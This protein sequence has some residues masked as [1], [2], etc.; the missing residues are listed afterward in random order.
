MG[1]FARAATSQYK[2]GA[3]AMGFF[4]RA[5]TSQYKPGAEAMGLRDPALPSPA[6]VHERA[7]AIVVD[8]LH[9]SQ[10]LGRERWQVGGAGVV[11]HL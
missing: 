2:P 8:L 5:A 6:V 7:D 10:R 1:F 3:E 11:L 4:A 9:R